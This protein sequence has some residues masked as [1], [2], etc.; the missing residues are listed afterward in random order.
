[1]TGQNSAKRLVSRAARGIE[2]EVPVPGDK[3]VSHRA[4]IIAASAVGETRIRGLLEGE[5]VLATLGAVRALGARAVREPPD[6]DDDGAGAVWRVRGLGVGGLAEPAAALDLGNSGTGARLLMG[7]VAAH[8]FTTVFSGDASLSARPMGRVMAP[9]KR[10]GVSFIARTGD[11]L[12][13]TVTGARDPVP[14]SYRL[15]VA[16]AQ[17]K[18]AVLLAGL[19]T[20]GTTTVVEP[21][22]TRDHSELLLRHFGAEVTVEDMA[23]GGRSVSIVGQPELA[24]R[25]VI[26]PGDLSSAAFPLVAALLVPGSRVVLRGVGVNPL[27]AG[28]L[29]TLREM[30]APIELVNPRSEAGEP[31][32]DISV[33]SATLRGVDV[34][35]ARAP[36]M[37][38]EYPIL[39]VAAACAAGTTRMNGLAELRLKESDRLAAMARGLAA[40]GVAVEESDDA[41]IVHGRGKPPRGDAEITVDLDHRIAMAFLVLGLVSERPIAVDD[42]RPIDTSFPG[43]ANLMNGLGAQ[44]EAEPAPRAEPKP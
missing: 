44:I 3:S 25:D 11:R 41:L 13:V 18:S 38:D 29:A 10:M 23:D 22:P 42:G 4:L 12:P 35:A 34:P 37:I 5:D 28:L 7:L 39:A 21:S 2:G 19:N 24:G 40:A 15:P 16:S 14:I 6:G 31:V 26:V 32:A 20:P 27:R 33:G 17:F 8:P 30:G 43:F 9:L 36:A 1:M